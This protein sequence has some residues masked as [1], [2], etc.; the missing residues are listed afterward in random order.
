MHNPAAVLHRSS[1]GSRQGHGDLRQSRAARMHIA[2]ADGFPQAE[3]Y[4]LVKSPRFDGCFFISYKSNYRGIEL[5][6]NIFREWACC[7]LF[8][9]PL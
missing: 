2:E 9:F 7:C 5:I 3:I 1:W 8:T 6:V 4:D